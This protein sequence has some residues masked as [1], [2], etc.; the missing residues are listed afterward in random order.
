MWAVRK[1]YYTCEPCGFLR[2]ESRETGNMGALE[3]SVSESLKA[4]PPE[5]TGTALAQ[6]VLYL[7]RQRSG[8]RLREL[9]KVAG[10]IDY[11]SVQKAVH[12]LGHRLTQDWRLQ[13]VVNKLE[14]Q[15]SDVET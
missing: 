9:A 13:A 10:G 12:R 4:F 1:G 6:T 11:T 2:E 14:T 8:M 3:A 15:L 5:A 7:A